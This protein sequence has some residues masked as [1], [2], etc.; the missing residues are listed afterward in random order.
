MWIGYLQYAPIRGALKENLALLR[1]LLES[2]LSRRHVDL[3]VLPELCNSGYNLKT[4][5]RTLAAAEPVQDSRFIDALADICRRHK[6]HIVSGFNE[7]DGERCYNSA[8]LIGPSG[9]LGRYRK[10]HLFLNEKDL[11]E[12]GDVGLPVFDIGLCK[13]GMLVCFD[14]M[15]PEAWRILALKGAD[16]IC[17]PSNLVL[18]GFCQKAVPVHALVNRIFAI[19]GNRIGSEEELT[20]TG[21]STIAGP[22]GDVLLQGPQ[23]EVHFGA[24]EID[25]TRARDKR[26]TA[27]ND[28]FLDR[29]PDLY[30]ALSAPQAA[31]S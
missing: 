4:R 3:L 20:F 10:L 29:R 16:V 14:W 8:V 21:L 22:K 7:R 11:F 31:R 18:P 1:R 2:E 17:H 13:L 26:I 24:C 19:T 27:R 5:E 30:D 12:P 15:F 9:Y 6:L 23:A 25:P 28:A